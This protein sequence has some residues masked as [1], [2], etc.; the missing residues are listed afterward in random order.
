MT[1]EKR[2]HITD[3]GHKH[4]F[5]EANVPSKVFAEILEDFKKN[6]FFAFGVATG[7]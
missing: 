5:V 2:V 3:L 6:G 1:Y 4:I 7:N